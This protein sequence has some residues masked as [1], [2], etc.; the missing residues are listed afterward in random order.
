MADSFYYELSNVLVVIVYVSQCSLLE[1]YHSKFIIS[2]Y[3]WL[4]AAALTDKIRSVGGLTIQDRTYRLRTYNTCFVGRLQCVTVI[5]CYLGTSDWLK[6]IHSPH[7]KRFVYTLMV[8]LGVQHLF[9]SQ[10]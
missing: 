10:K 7:H 9:G 5:I 4:Q 8:I 3:P 1:R 6:E 2:L